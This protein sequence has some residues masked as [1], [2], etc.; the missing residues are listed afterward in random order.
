MIKRRQAGQRL[1]R[2]GGLAA[3]YALGILVII[4]LVL[5]VLNRAGG[6]TGA[7]HPQLDDRLAPIQ[8]VA[9][10][11]MAAA[12][13]LERWA[14]N[15]RN[16]REENDRL[17]QENEELREWYALALS[18]RD[19]MERYEELLA[20]NADP[21][22]KVVTA[23][24]V[25]DTRG[26]FNHRRLLN[27]GR[28]DGVAEYQAVMGDRGL[29]GIVVRAGRRSSRVMLVSDPNSAIPVMVDRNNA[30]AILDGDQSL[31]PALI[32]ARTGLGLREG[33]RVVT[34]G[35]AGKLPRGL[36]VGVA[37]RDGLTWRVRLFADAGSVDYVRVVQF[38]QPVPP[39]EEDP[40]PPAEPEEG[41]DQA[42]AANATGESD[43]DQQ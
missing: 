7:S 8:R 13:R 29:V 33:D 32:F 15:R 31:D 1:D 34:S 2:F 37:Y 25:Q 36:P 12:R 16:L 14:D 6:W 35:D 21:S 40:D 18:M 38:E 22:A 30:R 23:R 27:A 20:L 4:T 42:L 24:V 26:P 9:A 28:R 19:K 3:R 11:P 5:V 10:A 41:R 39:E 17:R 43:G